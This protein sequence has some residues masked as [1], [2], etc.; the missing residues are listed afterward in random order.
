[1]SKDTDDRRCFS[2][3]PRGQL[4][5]IGEGGCSDVSGTYS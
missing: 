5:A 3:S 1:M 2:A 4:A